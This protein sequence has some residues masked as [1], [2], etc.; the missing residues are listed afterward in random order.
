MGNGRPD[1]AKSCA[2]K[3][4]LLGFQVAVFSTG[5]L[6]VL[7]EYIPK[8]VTPDPTL[9]KMIYETLPLIG[10]GQ[11]AMNVG[12]MCWSV[13]GAQGRFR[14]AT[15]IEFVASWF[16]VIPLSAALVFGL[17]FNLQG[18]VGAT[19]LGYAISGATNFYVVLRSDWKKLSDIVVERHEAEESSSSSSS[20]ASAED[21][22]GSMPD[23]KSIATD[24][25]SP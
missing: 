21:D 14:L 7:A 3:C 18:L 16:V 4:I 8:W 20:S 13:I 2:L 24:A 11:L 9:Q 23:S 5:V 12:I 25:A 17:R 19:V 1:R 15:T 6:Y 22:E 10:I